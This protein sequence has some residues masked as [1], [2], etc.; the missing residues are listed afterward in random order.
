MVNTPSL[1]TVSPCALLPARTNSPVPTL[2]IAKAPE[3]FPEILSRPAATFTVLSASNVTGPDHVLAPDE[4]IQSRA[5][6]GRVSEVEHAVDRHVVLE[7]QRR[8]IQDR[9]STGG[10][11]SG[12][13][14]AQHSVRDG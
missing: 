7:F 6:K 13:G 11:C 2:V 9:R 12:C 10:Q 3:T 14:Y 4:A 5:A 1:T 8:A